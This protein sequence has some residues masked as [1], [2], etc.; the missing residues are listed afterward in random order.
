MDN[1]NCSILDQETVQA[2]SCTLTFHRETKEFFT[3]WLRYSDD[4]RFTPSYQDACV[5]FQAVKMALI[6]K[7]PVTDCLKFQIAVRN[8][9]TSNWWPIQ[10]VKKDRFDPEG[11]A[12]FDWFQLSSGP[13]TC[14]AKPERLT[15][16]YRDICQAVESLG[17][18]PEAYF[19]EVLRSPTNPHENYHTGCTQYANGRQ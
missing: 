7:R 10:P 1:P 9:G 17:L 15:E 11:T 5:F 13:I 16:I 8:K 3:M 18:E 12:P 2:G 4:I 19:S 6:D 14:Y